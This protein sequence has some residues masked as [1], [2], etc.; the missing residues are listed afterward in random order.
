MNEEKIQ[1]ALKFLELA[2]QDYVKTGDFVD[3]SRVLIKLIYDLEVK[4]DQNY[5]NVTPYVQKRGEEIF[6]NNKKSLESHQEK[7]DKKIESLKKA[8]VKFIRGIEKEIRESFPESVDISHLE[9]KIQHLE[10]LGFLKAS[11]ME[12]LELSI[13]SQMPLQNVMEIIE[14]I[15]GLKTDKEEWKID[16]SHIKNLPQ[17]II[18]QFFGGDSGAPFEPTLKAG[19]N[20]T[21]R[22]DASGAFIISS[23][24]GG[25][26]DSFVDNEVVAG[27]NTTWI[28][29]ITPITGSVHLYANGQRL[30]PTVDYSIASDTITTVLSWDAGT[31]IADYRY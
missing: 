26:S 22:R 14:A 24:G 9:Q 25:S 30:T 1:K 28:L 2:D 7:I 11:D 8:M 21:I 31:V 20:I 23:T 16:A 5:N 10:D 17:P 27:S 6:R 18:Q 19:A 29:S 15:N 12:A 13:L 3:F 4:T